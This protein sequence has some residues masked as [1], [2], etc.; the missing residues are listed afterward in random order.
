MKHTVATCV[1]LLVASQW[2]LVHA[3]LNVNA[4]LEVA[5]GRQANGSWHNGSC[6]AQVRVRG[7]RHIRRILW[8]EAR[9]ARR[10]APRQ[11]RP[12]HPLARGTR[13]GASASTRSR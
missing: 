2:R 3:E 5:H 4:E 1:H 11:A 10:E 8:R 12:F 13:H 6:K 9:C 7:G